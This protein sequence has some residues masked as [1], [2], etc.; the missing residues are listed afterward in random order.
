M[1]IKHPDGNDG[2]QYLGNE[3][4]YQRSAGAKTTGFLMP[5]QIFKR[6]KEAKEKL[7]KQNLKNINKFGGETLNNKFPRHKFGMS[8][9]KISNFREKSVLKKSDKTIL[10]TKNLP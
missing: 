1:A 4:R 3:E 8:E 10:K 9:K 5:F 6:R 7:Q 2:W